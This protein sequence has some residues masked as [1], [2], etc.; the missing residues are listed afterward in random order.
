MLKW[1]SLVDFVLYKEGPALR[2]AK[3]KIIGAFCLC[4]IKLLASLC[5][6]RDKIEFIDG[7]RVKLQALRIYH[8]TSDR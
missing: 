2:R 8:I 6:K 4:V 7:F 1:D 5:C 3:I